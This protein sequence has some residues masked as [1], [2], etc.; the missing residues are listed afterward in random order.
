MTG[1]TTLAVTLLAL[2]GLVCAR[3]VAAQDRPPE[4]ELFGAPEAEDPEPADE[5]A[6]AERAGGAA[7]A[8]RPVEAVGRDPL[9]IGGILYLRSL[10]SAR[11]GDAVEAWQLSLPA[12][13]DGYFDARPNGRVRG[14]VLA[15][16][17]YDAAATGATLGGFGAGTGTGTGAASDTIESA[18]DPRVVLDQLWVRFDI[19]RRVF[20]TAGKQHVKW[21]TARFWTPSDFLH[22]ERRDPLAVF[23]ERT[24]VTMLKL[25]VP[26]EDRG[27]NLY[28]VA[29]F[30]LDGPAS[31][32]GSIVGA[33][34]AEVVLGTAE[35][36]ADVLGRRG[37]KPRVAADVSA[38]IG[39]FDVYIDVAL[40]T[41]ERER[42][43]R[44]TGACPLPVLVGCE[45][46][47]DAYFEP[48]VTVGGDWSYRYSDQD[49]ITIG[50]EYFENPTGYDD[51]DLYTIAFA[52]GELVPF[53]AGRRYAG[54]FALLPRPGSWNDT[55]FMFSTLGNLSDRS[56]VSRLDYQV[57]VLTYMRLELFGSVHYGRRGGELR[58]A[59][60]LPA[61]DLG[62][63]TTLPP[64]TVRAPVFEAGAA[65][66]IGL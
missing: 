61:L 11:E 58:F 7:G 41:A 47:R 5:E 9:A 14:F 12:I 51:P 40:T 57:L 43:R 42:W 33:A 59:T 24:G 64:T 50:A 53:Y 2:A 17:H 55:S 48:A 36:G 38:G 66:Q 31:D 49:S 26:W 10:V 4:D 22:P 29:A 15:R 30:D 34:R 27:W 32:V 3:N 18:D 20:V 65:L 45:R 1:G 6:G 60:S 54:V 19:A 56:F 44:G 37:E 13:V 35:L 63:G 21:G 46:T 62:G 8:D 16:M 28:G 23:D 39:A 52:A 25:H